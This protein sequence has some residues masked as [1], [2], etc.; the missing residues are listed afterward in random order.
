MA[1]IKQITNT[2]SLVDVQLTKREW[3]VI[4]ILRQIRYGDLLVQK[5]S[6]LII[7]I[8]PMPTIKMDENMN[9][10]VTFGVE[11]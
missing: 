8:K 6:G 5:Q 4:Q 9:I 10:N 2:E 3:N 1:D 7:M 11:E